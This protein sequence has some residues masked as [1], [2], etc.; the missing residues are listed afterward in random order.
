[1]DSVIACKYNGEITIIATG[2]YVEL[3]EKLEYYKKISNGKEI[4]LIQFDNGIPEGL[5]LNQELINEILSK[6]FN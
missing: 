4:K 2:N 1:M 5:I 3:S 6:E